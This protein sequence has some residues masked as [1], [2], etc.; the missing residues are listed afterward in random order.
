MR[1]WIQRRWQGR[2][3]AWLSYYITM[4][5]LPLNV[6]AWGLVLALWLP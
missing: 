2:E 5:G 4:I 1:A 3:P 6:L